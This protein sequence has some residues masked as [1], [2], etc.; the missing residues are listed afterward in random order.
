MNRLPEIYREN[1]NWLAGFEVGLKEILEEP[2]QFEQEKCFNI[3]WRNKRTRQQYVDKIADPSVSEE[4]K[5]CY[6]EGLVVIDEHD[7][8]YALA[9]GWCNHDLVGDMYRGVW[10][11]RLAGLRHID[12]PEDDH[13]PDLDT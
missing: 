3:V 8:T 11:G 5:Q 9:L 2:E 10:C 7:I 1:E 13:W 12:E 4:I 6:R